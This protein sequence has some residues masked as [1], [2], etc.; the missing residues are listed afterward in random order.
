MLGPQENGQNVIERYFWRVY[1]TADLVLDVW[2]GAGNENMVLK[3]KYVFYNGGSQLRT[4]YEF[5]TV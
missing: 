1:S 5:H 4:H 2:V 3:S